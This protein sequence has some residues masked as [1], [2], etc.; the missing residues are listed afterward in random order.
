MSARRIADRST[1]AVP[2]L[3]LAV[4]AASWGSDPA[5]PVV[6]VLDLFLAGGVL[7]AVHHAEVI[8]RRV[9][10]PFGSL[11]LAVAVTV[12]E[13]A[14]IVTLMVSG[15]EETETLARDTVFAAVMI[16]CNGIVGLSILTAAL[17]GRLA[18][19]NA[20]GSATAFATVITLA[21]LSLVLPTFTTSKTGPEF[22]ASQLAFAAVASICLYGLFLLVQTVRHRGFFLDSAEDVAADKEENEHGPPPSRGAALRSLGLLLVALVAV[23]GLAK[24]SSGAIEDGVK[25]IGAPQSAVGV[26]IALLVLM[27]E[28]L[29]AWR[30]ARRGRVQVSFNLAYGSA[31]ASIGLT[32]PAIAIASIWLSGPLVLGLGATQIGLLVLTGIVSA[33]TLLPGRATLQE[34]GVHLIILAAFLFLALNP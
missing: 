7:A 14:L 8:A 11:V 2:L 4:M 26:V 22:S 9:G 23:V 5:T 27:P 19:F 16:T 24:L 31:M 6:V 25:S 12:I 33:L 20:E 15:G 3:A 30:N 18:S 13:V 21:T 29:T 32:I 34:G 10:E 17:R 28:T 1:I